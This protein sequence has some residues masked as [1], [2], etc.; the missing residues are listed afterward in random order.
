MIRERIGQAAL[1]AY[2][3]AV[4][5]TRGLEM[6]GMLLDAGEQS[7]R[8]FVHDS[9]S[10]VLGG[11][12]ERR[13][14][15]ARAGSRRLLADSCCQAVIILLMLWLFSALNTQVIT[16]PTHQLL[17][18]EL[19]LAAILACALIGYERIAAL[20]ALAALIAYGPLGQHTQP[21][22]LAT[23]LVPIACLL[24][25]VRGPASVAT[26]QLDSALSAEG[27]MIADYS[28]HDMTTRACVER[29]SEV[30]Q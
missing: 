12:R 18:Q 17:V 3:P 7:G 9:W 29:E 5:Q 10:L 6:L 19:V 8:A 27:N 16:G 24:V 14:I 13:A 26:G 28:A 21:V 20:S 23:V 11:L 2:P 25:M 4:R 22:L 15:T 30:R 1:R